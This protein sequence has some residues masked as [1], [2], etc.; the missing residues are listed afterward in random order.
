MKLQNRKILVTGASKGIG[1]AITT[2]LIKQG[3][4]VIGIARDFSSWQDQPAGLICLEA[5]LSDLNHLPQQMQTIVKDH[6]DIDGIIFNAGFGRFGSLEE[7]SPSQIQ[8]QINLNLTSQILL[9]RELLPTLKRQ[10]RGD[11]IFIGSEAALSGR[12]KGSIYCATKFAIRG[13]AQSL[14]EE[15]SAAGIRSTIINPGMVKTGFFDELP[16]EPGEATENYILPEDIAGAAITILSARPG[17]CFDEI[18]LSPLKKVV[19]FK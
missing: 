18:N 4:S 7:F 9:A 17:T 3:A 6:P 8:D 16:F 15:C 1:R 12:R 13:F 19:R 14:R 11:L 5:D 10:G 2:D